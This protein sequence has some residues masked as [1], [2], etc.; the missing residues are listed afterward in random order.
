ME[1]ATAK[2]QTQSR[3]K[4]KDTARAKKNPAKIEARNRQKHP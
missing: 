4:G 3:K 2:L 1:T